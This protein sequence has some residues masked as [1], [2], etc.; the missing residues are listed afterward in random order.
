MTFH[1]TKKSL[2]SKKHVCLFSVTKIL[3]VN[4][5][6]LVD[7]LLESKSFA[8]ELKS[9]ASQK[10]LVCMLNWRKWAGSTLMDKRRVSI[11]RFE[12]VVHHRFLKRAPNKHSTGEERMLHIELQKGK[13]ALCSNQISVCANS[14]SVITKI[15]VLHYISKYRVDMYSITLHV[16]P[17]LLLVVDTFTGN[18]AGHNLFLTQ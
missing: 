16:K 14:I 12:L 9:F 7:I 5:S 1:S 10:V 18:K 17:F 4:Q 11:C 13:L 15:F 2:Q 8:C 6:S 3:V